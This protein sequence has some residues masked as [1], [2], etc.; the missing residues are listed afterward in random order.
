MNPYLGANG[1]KAT[2]FWSGGNQVIT[3]G[4]HC[5]GG[6][7]Y[8]V[9]INRSDLNGSRY[10]GFQTTCY[11]TACSPPLISELLDVR[12]IDLQA[13][14]STPPT[15]SAPGTAN[16]WAQEGKF[17]RGTWPA[18]FQA[19]DDSGI[20]GMYVTVDG[21]TI[22]GPLDAHPDQGSWTQCPSPLTMNQAVDTS[23]YPDGPLTLKLGA[24]DAASPANVTSPAETLNVDNQPVHVTI[25]GPTDAPSTAGVQRLTAQAAA[26]PSGVADIACSV[27]DSPFT[28]Q[29]GASVQIPIQ[30]VGQHHVA[31][32]AE[33]NALDVHGAAGRSALAT[34]TLGIRLPSVISASFARIVNPLHCSQRV[35]RVKVPAHWV[36]VRR[37]GRTIRIHRRATSRRIRVTR[38]HPRLVRRRVRVHGRWQVVEEPVFPHQTNRTLVRVPF[39]HTTSVGGWLGHTDGTALPGQSVRILSAPDDG[40]DNFTQIATSSTAPDGIWRARLPAGPSR[41]IEAVYPG[42]ANTEPAASG[43]VRVAVPSR[44]RLLVRPAGVAWGRS[45]LISGRVLGG[46]IPANK[47][48]VSQLLRLRIGI[49]GVSET[50]GIPDVQRDGRFRTTYC[51]NPG[52][53]IAHFWFS[54]STLNE[55][56][57]PYEPASSR[58]AEVRVGPASAAQPC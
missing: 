42:S 32:Y 25:S 22:P 39:G 49:Q 41:L 50:A 58:R 34:W 4:G 19:R 18:D 35:V 52:R 9:G 10:F 47:T 29:A 54:V 36:K 2:F 20:C 23:L 6:M 16:L 15:L 11:A 1:W 13:V 27:D 46:Y 38:C 43:D 55:T 12:G 14:D 37:H 7:D 5:C 45:V 17:V 24:W 56:D 51:F 30:G 57:Y 31:C 33:N 44:I 21:Q 48:A 3:S 53:G 28:A 8:G 40:S 26:G